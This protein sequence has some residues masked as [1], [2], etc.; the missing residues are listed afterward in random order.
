[1]AATGRQPGQADER[2]AH[3]SAVAASVF[4]SRYFIH[5]GTG[6]PPSHLAL[7]DTAGVAPDMLAQWPLLAAFEVEQL[8]RLHNVVCPGRP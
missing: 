3:S 2:S 7:P 8:L 4:S 6:E 1:M 5:R